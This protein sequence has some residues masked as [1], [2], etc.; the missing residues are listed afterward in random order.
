MR[1]GVAFALLT[2]GIAIFSFWR[3]LSG[4]RS[5]RAKIS[6]RGMSLEADREDDPVGFST[7]VWL[8]VSIGLFALACA[9]WLILYNH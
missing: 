1:A 3:A 9:A 8:N 6:L 7:A 5:G 2:I 4:Y